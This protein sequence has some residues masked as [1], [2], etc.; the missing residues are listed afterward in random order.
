MRVCVLVRVHVCDTDIEFSVF[1]VVDKSCT[2]DL[3]LQPSSHT[4]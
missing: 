1:W 4:V 3:C 2:T